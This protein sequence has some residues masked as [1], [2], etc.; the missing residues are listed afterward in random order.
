MI[1]MHI[2][3]RRVACFAVFLLV[4]G[5]DEHSLSRL[6]N[7]TGLSDVTDVVGNT[8]TFVA[9]QDILCSGAISII[10]TA[11]CHHPIHA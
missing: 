6:A 1:L 7:G 10:I 9:S 4:D 8:E 3:C 5:S 2:A 11:L